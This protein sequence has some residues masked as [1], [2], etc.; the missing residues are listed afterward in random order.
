M[1]QFNRRIALFLFLSTGLLG[2]CGGEREND[3]VSLT[4]DNLSVALQ[5]VVDLSVIPAVD[6][7]AAQS[8]QLDDSVDLFCLAP[9]IRQLSNV[10]ADWITLYGDWF[11]LANYNFGPLDDDLI[12]PAFTFIDS[13]RLRGTDYLQTVRS[14]IGLDIAGSQTLNSIYF[15]NKTFQNVGLLALESALFETSVT[16]SGTQH[17]SLGSDIVSEFQTSTR[18]CKIISGLSEQLVRHGNAIQNGWRVA[19]KD[20]GVNY[21]TL[22]LSAQLEDG[23]EPL[24]LLL[25][26]IQDHLDYLQKRNVAIVSA[27]FSGQAWQGIALSIDE[28]EQFLDGTDQTTISLFSLL[29]SAGLDT[30]VLQIKANINE[31]RQ[32]IDERDPDMLNIALGKLDGNFKREIP[33]G[34]DVELGVNFS[35]GD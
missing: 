31:I 3:P 4:Q 6:K 9:T 12:F 13:L 7:F 19:F 25:T 16:E 30:A 11:R 1:T 26:M 24:T 2:A 27:P 35:D 23:T 28:I 21:R 17:S 32:R 5:E 10:Q 18:K 20:T 33:D 8:I 34:L 22:F 29:D 14:E 15:A